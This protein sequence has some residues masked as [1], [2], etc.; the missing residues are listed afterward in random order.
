[1]HEHH[2]IHPLY[3]FFLPQGANIQCK[4]TKETNPMKKIWQKLSFPNPYD[5]NPNQEHKILQNII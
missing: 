5:K 2:E 4:S 1:M 3:M